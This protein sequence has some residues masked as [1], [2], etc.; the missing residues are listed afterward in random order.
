[1]LVESKI[2]TA[3]YCYSLLDHN[4]GNN[5][6]YDKGIPLDEFMQ[7]FHPSELIYDPPL[8]EDEEPSLW[9][10]SRLVR[11]DSVK[12]PP[13]PKGKLTLDFSPLYNFSGNGSVY[14]S[15]SDDTAILIGGLGTHA[16]GRY[17]YDSRNYE[18]MIGFDATSMSDVMFLLVTVN[19]KTQKV[20]SSLNGLHRISAGYCGEY[21]DMKI[22]FNV[23]WLA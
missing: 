23:E 13:T 14:I 6:V 2:A 9:D 10:S 4:P 3:R 19:G 18:V 20:R 11:E 12:I 7:M 1:M 15:W 21:N 5:S 22:L 8:P 16:G 17:V